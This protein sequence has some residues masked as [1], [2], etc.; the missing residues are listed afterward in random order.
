[1]I[2]HIQASTYVLPD[3]MGS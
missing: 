3:Q 1:M 2:F